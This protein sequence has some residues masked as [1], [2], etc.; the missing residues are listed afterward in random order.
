M[1]LV[2]KATRK[3]AEAWRA[4]VN[5]LKRGTNA[6]KSRFLPGFRNK[7]SEMRNRFAKIGS[8]LKEKARSLFTAVPDGGGRRRDR[9]STM[10]KRRGNKRR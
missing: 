4:T 2:G 5:A 6:V 1:P 9:R 3:A 7:L 10:K 8:T